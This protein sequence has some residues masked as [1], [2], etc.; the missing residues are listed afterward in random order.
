MFQLN[1]LFLI[2]FLFGCS[3]SEVNV[4][5]DK[6]ES[7]IAE[8]WADNWFEMYVNG[9]K[10]LEDSVSINTERSFNAEKFYFSSD[11]P[12]VLAFKIKDFKANDTGLE[13]IGTKRQQIGDG[14]F[15]A[16]IR[17]TKTGAILAVTNSEVRC[18]VLHRAPLD[19]S[20]AQELSPVAGKGKCK[21]KTYKEPKAWIL[22]NFDD[23]LW[24][25]AIVHSVESVR[26]KDGYDDILWS[27]SAKL[28]WSDDL[29]KDNTLICR[30]TFRDLKKKS[31]T[32]EKVKNSI[33]EAGF[34]DKVSVY[35]KNGTASLSSKTFPDHEMMT[36]I[37]QTNEQ[38]PVPAKS[39]HAPI[40][41]ESSLST[42]PKTRD[43]ALGIA[44]N[45]VPIYDYTGGGEMSDED[46]HHHQARHDTF[47]TKQL[48]KC[49]GHAG[50]GDDYHYHKRPNCMIDSMKNSDKK[51][52]I[53][54]WAFDGYPIFDLTHPDGRA[55]DSLDLDVCNG[56][57]DDIFG[58]RYHTTRKSPYIIQC[59]MG[60]I[61]GDLKSLPRVAPL[62]SEKSG[63]GNLGRPPRGGVSNL[64][65]R[66]INPDQ[67]SMSYTYKG[68]SYYIKYSP[69]KNANCYFFETKTVT[70]NGVEKKVELCR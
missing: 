7:F 68:E 14:G 51:D 39:Y 59:L 43:A 58:Y 38:V 8:I 62:K 46:L 69:S 12:S 53:I 50:R 42:S 28:I 60:V 22:P 41:L 57:V 36:G 6:N 65:Y 23:S 44:V 16:Q 11:S 30:M 19:E 29:K 35:C 21:F 56:I 3:S 25:H 27:P 9:K 55:I 18:M 64:K 4:S 15:I 54:G 52:K 10:K 1:F 17:D 67:G 49:G 45:G 20:C 37:I 31:K 47:Q 5:G 32:C 26:P 70:N 40:P 13:Y 34:E 63:D 33:L 48:D 66:Q 2:L 61:K 24:P